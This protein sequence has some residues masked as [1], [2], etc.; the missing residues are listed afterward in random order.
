LESQNGT[1]MNN[2]T[3]SPL[4]AYEIPSGTRL[5]FGELALTLYFE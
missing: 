4:V 1:Q 3:L 5:Q 2:L